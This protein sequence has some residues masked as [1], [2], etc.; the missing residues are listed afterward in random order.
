MTNILGQVTKGFARRASVSARFI[1]TASLTMVMVVV[2]AWGWVTSTPT[3]QPL[4]PVPR[5]LSPAEQA[6]IAQPIAALLPLHKQLDRPERGEWLD[7]HE[8]A[9]QNYH[10][11]VRGEPVCV[12]SVRRT[13]Y[14][15][16]LGEFTP[17]ERRVVAGASEFLSAAFQLPVL[18]LDDLSLD[19]IPATARRTHPQWGV[20]QILATY[21]LDEVLQPRLPA[22]AVTYI[23]L[24]TA[25]L[26]TGAGSNFVFGY[27]SLEGR[28]GVWSID[29]F[30]DPGESE[31]A[32]RTALLRTMKISVHETGH[33]FSL[34]HCV[35]FECVMNGVNHLQ[36]LDRRPAA[37]CPLCLAKIVHATGADPRG[38][39]EA[40][41]RFADAQGLSAERKFWRRSLEMIDGTSDGANR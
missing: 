14:V 9:G 33:M 34:A 1:A 25:D 28:V 32:F 13:I 18:V 30:G 40:C 31:E 38:H 7:T 17:A 41:A 22:D 5:P 11:Y 16:P 23:G 6:A 10:Q 37:F 39:M 19:A 24:T 4:R 27:A 15:Q 21:V 26:W 3:P 2:G 36:E 12:G 29:R 20:P 35:N 8:E